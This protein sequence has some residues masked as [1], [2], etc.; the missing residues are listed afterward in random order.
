[1]LYKVVLTFESVGEILK[2]YNVHEIIPY[3]LMNALY[4]S[5]TAEYR[6]F[7]SLHASLFKFKSF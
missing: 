7:V 6:L 5:L 4:R 3:V 1:M 2:C